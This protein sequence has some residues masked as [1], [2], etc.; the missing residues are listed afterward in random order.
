VPAPPPARRSPVSITHTAAAPAV[1]RPDPPLP[2]RRPGDRS[3]RPP[4]RGTA[5]AAPTAIQPLSKPGDP[6]SLRSPHDWSR[7][8]VEIP[9]EPDSR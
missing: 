6:P 7:S 8:D 3:G 1:G 5:R 2:W 4:A 9:W